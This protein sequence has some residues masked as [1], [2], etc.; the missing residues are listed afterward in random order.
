[1]TTRPLREQHSLS[2]KRSE[3]GITLAE[4]LIALAIVGIGLV[5]LAAVVP[6]SS[7]GLQEGNQLST[8]TFLAEQRIEQL[9]AAAWTATP[10]VDCLGTSTSWSFSDA[11]AAPAP[12]GG[13]T[14]ASFPDE[15]PAGSTA[16]GPPTKLDDPHGSY[17]RQVRIRPCDAVGSSCGISDSNLRQATVRVSYVPLQAVGGVATSAKS[18]ELT[19][20]LARRS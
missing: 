19:M 8:A 12:G 1:M 15:T 11:A 5:G 17:T 20:L 14:P 7:Y 6:I 16:A 2:G 13:C 18:V 4:I 10:A 9:K 3:G